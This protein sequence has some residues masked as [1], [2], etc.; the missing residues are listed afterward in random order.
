MTTW[1]EVTVKHTKRF[2]VEMLSENE[3]G[4]V[5]I[6]IEEI[7]NEFDEIEGEMVESKDVDSLLRHTDKDKTFKL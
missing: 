1:Y 4:A 5:D 7:N 3:N 2:A 6:I